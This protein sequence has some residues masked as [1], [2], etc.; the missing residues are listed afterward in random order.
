MTIILVH[1]LAEMMTSA[2]QTLVEKIAF[3]NAGLTYEQEILLCA[4]KYQ[5]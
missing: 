4:G 3:V 1:C 2:N 5:E